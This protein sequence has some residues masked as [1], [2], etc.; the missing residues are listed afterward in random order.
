MRLQIVNCLL[1][2]LRSLPANAS[3]IPCISTT[4]P[5]DTTNPAL[6]CTP[7]LQTGNA[8][9][10]V[11]TGMFASDNYD[12]RSMTTPGITGLFNQYCL[13]SAVSNLITCAPGDNTYDG[14]QT[15]VSLISDVSQFHSITTTTG[16]NGKDVYV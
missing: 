12:W 9:I 5:R 6:Y 14:V 10:A 3:F 13:T 15:S 16:T 11:L 8:Q 7:V 1:P 2:V 4:P